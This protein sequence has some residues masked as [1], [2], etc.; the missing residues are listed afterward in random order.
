MW[1]MISAN[2]TDLEN[3]LYR[4]ERALDWP[5][6]YDYHG[7]DRHYSNNQRYYSKAFAVEAVEADRDTD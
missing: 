6:S 3:R 4:N 2:S 5:S 1:T 7:Q